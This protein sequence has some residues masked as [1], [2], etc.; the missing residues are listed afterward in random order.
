MVFILEELS[1]RPSDGLG[2]KKNNGSV[3]ALIPRGFFLG[4]FLILLH[5]CSFLLKA[6]RDRVH[7]G[8]SL[9]MV[10]ECELHLNC[11]CC[12]GG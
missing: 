12:S 1:T 8:F 10:P 4:R 11:I 3:V 2:G 7:P 5:F 9:V 6:K